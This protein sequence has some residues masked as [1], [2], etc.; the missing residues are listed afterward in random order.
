MALRKL[1]HESRYFLDLPVQL[2]LQSCYQYH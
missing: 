2:I 1:E